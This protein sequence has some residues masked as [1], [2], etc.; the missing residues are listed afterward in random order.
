MLP[1]ITHAINHASLLSFPPPS[2]LIPF[3]PFLHTHTQPFVEM[4][5]QAFEKLYFA[6]K[7]LRESALR[8]LKMWEFLS[9]LAEA[10]VTLGMAEHVQKRFNISPFELEDPMRMAQDPP[11]YV[12]YVFLPSHATEA[13]GEK[14]EMR[15]LPTERLYQSPPHSPSLL[16]PL[17]LLPSLSALPALFSVPP[18]THNRKKRT[19]TREEMKKRRREGG[20]E[21]RRAVPSRPLARQSFLECWRER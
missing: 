12:R 2:T 6:G 10:D 11:L 15:G 13:S 9:C 20:R 14:K 5:T 21:G 17:P 19:S 7:I 8:V 4:Y 3:C 18:T 16:Y 1:N